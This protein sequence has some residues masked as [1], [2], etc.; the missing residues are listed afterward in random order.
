MN[1]E[2]RQAYNKAY[3]HDNFEEIKL[4]QKAY[5]KDHKEARTAY[6]KA[7]YKANCEKI[8]AYQKAYRKANPECFKNYR[9]ANPEKEKARHKIYYKANTENHKAF[10]KA[11]KKA[12][13]DKNR[14]YAHTRRAL[15]CKTSYE[16]ISE[17]IVYF[18]DG[19]KC[20]ICHKSVDNKFNWPDS[21]S[22]SLDHIIP[23]S[24]G[25]THTYNNVQLAH[26]TC[27][28]SKNVNV[29]AQGEQMRIF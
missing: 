12:N 26:L 1:K 6:D 19:W 11:Y 7:H 28:L 29:L 27:N 15:K 17:K 13:P 4:Q 18:R 23:L 25:G 24:K 2:E 3:N 10:M 8:K 22:P 5:R 16:P 9:S 20:Q 21:M 14:E